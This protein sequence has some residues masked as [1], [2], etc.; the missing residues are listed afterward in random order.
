MATTAE[1]ELGRHV[2]SLVAAGIHATGAQLYVEHAGDVVVDEAW[3]RCG[4]LPMTPDCVHGAYCATKPVLAVAIGL[5][6][7]RGLLALDA[8]IVSFGDQLV[9][10]APEVTVADVLCHRAGL[11]RPAAIEWRMCPPAERA[12][13]LPFAPAPAP[14][15]SEIAGWL[16]LSAVVESATGEDPG[17]WIQ[18]EM[19]APLGLDHVVLRPDA[20]RQ[21][22][23]EGIVRVAVG[24]LPLEEIPLLSELLPRQLAEASPAF[25]GLVSARDLGRFYTGVRRVLEGDDVPGLPPPAGMRALLACRRGTTR[26]PVVR[27]ACD[28]A[29][30]FMIGLDEHRISAAASP[31]AIGHSAGVASTVG[32]CDPEHAIAIAL[33]L[34]GSTLTAE[35]LE[36][37]RMIVVDRAMAAVRDDLS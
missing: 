9:W 16:A 21:A 29:G 35:D 4:P 37:Q 14:A 31:E 36:L 3:G 30:G 7:D 33:H 22:L 11:A 6:A 12:A 26:D 25:S 27:R 24:G 34:N 19:L 1:A 18:R 28:F 2:E 17:E 23:D 10:V 20:A 32:L 15:Y 5:L 13:L 8:P